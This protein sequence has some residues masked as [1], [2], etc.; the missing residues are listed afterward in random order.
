MAGLTANKTNNLKTLEDLL[1]LLSLLDDRSENNNFLCSVLTTD[2][3]EKYDRPQTAI[4]YAFN[5]LMP[6]IRSETA[7]LSQQFSPGDIERLNSFHGITEITEAD[8]TIIRRVINSKNNPNTTN[9]NNIFP[10][11]SEGMRE[12]INNKICFYQELMSK[13]PSTKK[14]CTPEYLACLII[15][16]LR[17]FYKF[18]NY[19]RDKAVFCGKQN[20]GDRNTVSFSLF[21]KPLSERG[22]P[23]ASVKSFLEEIGIH[24]EQRISDTNDYL[25]AANPEE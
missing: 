5:S 23:R 8:V 6:I 9:F 7:V 4:V 21:S 3:E 13:N 12:V 19:L 2:K 1:W 10:A 15:E 14:L 25:D 24:G 17:I 22:L 16:D 18:L 20:E 11:L